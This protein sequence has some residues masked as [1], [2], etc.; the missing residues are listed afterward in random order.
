[1]SNFHLVFS[2]RI[3]LHIL[4]SRTRG[5]RNGLWHFQPF[6]VLNLQAWGLE[7]RVEILNGNNSLS[8]FLEKYQTVYLPIALSY[9]AEY[10][11]GS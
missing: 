9:R 7:L 6:L 4:M 8:C 10:K 11:N 3:F 5:C 1:M 2:A